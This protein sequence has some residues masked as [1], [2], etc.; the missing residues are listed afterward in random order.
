MYS[1]PNYNIFAF[2]I[3]SSLKTILFGTT[4]HEKHES[5]NESINASILIDLHSHYEKDNIHRNKNIMLIT[6][7]IPHTLTFT[8][9]HIA[10][11][12]RSYNCTVHQ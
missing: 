4:C 7:E 8:T 10:L 2:E 5:A 11:C 1:T 6:K 12:K 3:R 9:P